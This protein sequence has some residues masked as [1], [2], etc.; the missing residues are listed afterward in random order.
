[1][2]FARCTATV[3]TLSDSRSAIARFD[4]P[5]QISCS[6]SSSRGVSAASLAGRLG[7]TRDGRIEHRLAGGDALD[8]GGQIEVEC[9]L[10]HVSPGAGVH[11]LADQRFFRVHAEH[12]D[13]DVGRARHESCGSPRA[14]WC[15][16]SRRPSRRRRAAARRTIRMASSP[17]LALADDSSTG[18]SSSIRR[19][20]R[21]TSAWSSTRRTEILDVIQLPWVPR[22]GRSGARACRRRAGL[23]SSSVPPSSSARSRI[24]TSPS[25]RREGPAA[26]ALALGPPPRARSHHPAV[27]GARGRS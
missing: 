6:T 23:S 26:E 9:A 11:R 7:R 1:M 18:S 27:E 2:M 24:A 15:P 4:S 8:R 3:F 17:L 5:S 12:Q 25:P 22:P 13:L 10:E 19:N 16:A 20:P 14:R 21:R